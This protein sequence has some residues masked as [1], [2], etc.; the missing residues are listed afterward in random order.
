MQKYCEKCKKVY[1][2]SIKKCLEC[3]KKL[4][5]EYSPEEIRKME[6]TAIMNSITTIN[7]L[8]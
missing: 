7:T 3:G 2:S 5:K 8:F 1:D 6:E 4:K